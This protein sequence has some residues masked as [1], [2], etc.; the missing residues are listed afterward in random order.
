MWIHHAQD[1]RSV[2]GMRR[3]WVTGALSPAAVSKGDLGQIPHR[4][5]CS[6][7]LRVVWRICNHMIRCTCIEYV[8]VANLLFLREFC[9]PRVVHVTFKIGYR[10]LSPSPLPSLGE[11]PPFYIPL[12]HGA[13]SGSFDELLAMI[14]CQH[15]CVCHRYPMT[16]PSCCRSAW[17]SATA[18]CC[19]SAPPG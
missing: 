15:R 11:F 4:I 17:M 2:A 13:A 16:A 1:K 12:A 3:P 7:K 19:C 8:H 6:V 18:H 10:S 5:K 9:I 14:L